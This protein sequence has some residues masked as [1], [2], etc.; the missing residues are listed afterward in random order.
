MFKN[1]EFN[2]EEWKRIIKCQ[3]ND[4]TF[5]TTIQDPDILDQMLPLGIDQ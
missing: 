4:I 3:N 5:M 2:I 1:L